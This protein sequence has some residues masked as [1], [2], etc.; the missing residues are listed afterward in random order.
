[1]RLEPG[2]KLYCQ[3]IHRAL[4]LAE[5]VAEAGREGLTLT[6]LAAQAGLPMSTAYRLAQNLVS[7]DYLQ[8]SGEGAYRLGAAFI[9]YG[10]RLYR[11]MDI[12]DIAADEMQ[13]LALRTGQTVYL[14]VLNEVARRI[15]HVAKVRGNGAYQLTAGV[16]T[17]GH[18]HSTAAGKVLVSEMPTSRLREWLDEAGMPQ[19]CPATITSPEDFLARLERVRR[20]GCAMDMQE[21]EENVISVS[22]PVRDYSGAIVA[23]VSVS[24]IPGVAGFGEGSDLARKVAGVKESAAR[25]S[26][27]MS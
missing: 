21:N 2:D 20:E 14:S 10:L 3:S 6:A 25:I 7:W 17:A 16:G 1:M 19:M 27:A 24:G 13:A 11:E 8:E 4:K 26:R 9:R 15:V 22:A 5:L 12:T 23:A 18:I